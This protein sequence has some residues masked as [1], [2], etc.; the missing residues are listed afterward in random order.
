[1]KK[2]LLFTLVLSLL[3]PFGL[4]AQVAADQL[5]TGYCTIN[6]K[7]P[8][9]ADAWTHAIKDFNISVNGEQVASHGA[10]S[11]KFNNLTSSVVFNAAQGD[12]VTITF[13]NGG[14]SYNVWAGFDWDRDGNFDEVI[15]AY[16]E[17]TGRGQQVF[18]E[19]QG[20]IT[21]TVPDNAEVGKS[22]VRILSDGACDESLWD[23]ITAPLCG[24][25]G[26]GAIGYA[27]VYYDVAINVEEGV[28]TGNVFTV[29]ATSADATMGTAEASSTEVNEG[30]TV[31]LTATPEYGYGFVNWTVAGVEVSTENP[32]KPT[33]TA[34]TDFVA[35]FEALPMC[36]VTVTSSDATKGSVETS[37]TSVPQGEYV[38]ITATAQPGNIFI[39]WTVNGSPVSTE[40]PFNVPINADTEFVANF[41]ESAIII[42][43]EYRIKDVATNQYIT[44]FNTDAHTG[45]TNGGVGT[46]AFAENDNQ[47]M[48]FEESG[49]N[50]KIKTKSGYYIYA[51]A[52]NVD[53]LSSQ[54]TEFKFIDNGSGYYMQAYNTNKGNAWYH[55]KNE[56]VGG[57]YYLFADAAVG[58][59]ATWV[60]EPLTQIYTISLSVTPADG[61]EATA[62]LYSVEEGS[63]T[64]LTATPAEGYEFVNWTLG[65]VEVSTDAVYTTT[66]VT[67]NREYVANFK[68]KPVEPREV[69]VASSNNA[70]GYA[71][72]ISPAPS[73][74]EPSVT[75]GE[76]VTVKAFANGSDNFFVNWTINEVIV[77]TEETYT[78]IGEEA[79]TIQANFVS[80]YLITIND[81]SGGKINVT[82]GSSKISS[83]D[84]VQEGEYITV[85]VK[86]DTYKELKKLIV[87]G[88]DVYAQ[89]KSTKSYTTAVNSAMTIT[90][91]YGTPTCTLTWE[92]TGDGYIEVWTTDTYETESADWAEPAGDQYSMFD[93]APFD[94][95]IAIFVFPGGEPLSSEN[96]NKLL[97]LTV[98][99]EE[100]DL[101]EEGDLMM[102][103]DV[104]IESIKGPQHIVAEF[105]G[106]W[107][108]VE[109]AEIAENTIYAVAGGVQVEVAEATNVEVYS[110]AGTL[111]A[112]KVIS[113]TSTIALA[114]G[115]YIVKAEDKVTKVVVR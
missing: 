55:V 50:Y 112:E 88:V 82:S 40:N 51:Q 72:I 20:T 115:V 23:P 94:S 59:A 110:I 25:H 111:V 114:K 93:E 49:A 13:T 17:D 5:P 33:I 54:S 43:K 75:T 105:T 86:E 35:N 62:S 98:N 27:G 7:K 31:T 53:A 58:A 79:A 71:T 63:T 96:S 66:A 113:G 89:Y 19:D 78:Y 99:D 65:G 14:W 108:S 91:E 61:G 22:V 11:S 4:K 85:T 83:G 34:N 15:A 74:T 52:W 28:F 73:G 104:F 95:N 3:I 44:A 97:S 24:T 47:I 81:V 36:T 8:N 21:V 68:F 37:A 87:N 39:N 106:E 46:S 77:G 84:R 32:Y 9:W 2:I 45:G 56:S 42:G 12:E 70:K 67:E 16:P 38:T 80:K 29:S 60:L 26:A 76:M 69:R 30:R 57:T 64:T 10:P 1:M 18:T 103:G 102:F 48:I 41:E 90:A 6:T 100:I 101:S 107:N 109:S 92:H